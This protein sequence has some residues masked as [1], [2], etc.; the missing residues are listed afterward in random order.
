MCSG[1][2]DAERSDFRKVFHD[3]I[4]FVKSV[5]HTNVILVSIPYRYDLMSSDTNNEI[6]NFNRKLCKL[7]KIFSHVNTIE[8]DSNRQIFTTHGLHLNGLGKELL[9]SHILLYIYSA[10]EEVTGSL[11]VLAWQD[12]YLQASPPITISDNQDLI[13]N[14]IILDKLVSIPCSVKESSTIS[15]VNNN[16]TIDNLRLLMTR[17]SSRVKKARYKNIFLW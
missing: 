16:M 6:K 7:A 11:V 14:N 1:S 10:V 17:T 12:G 15:S 9:S 5:Q 2:N 13:S 4:S 3:V 8:V